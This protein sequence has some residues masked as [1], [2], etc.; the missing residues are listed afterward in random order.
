MNLLLELDRLELSGLVNKVLGLAMAE[1]GLHGD[2]AVGE[3]GKP[4]STDSTPNDVIVSGGETH[5]RPNDGG[6]LR[7]MTGTVRRKFQIVC[8]RRR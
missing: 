5:D 4:F 2:D 6:D 8:V 3:E 1:Q 7:V